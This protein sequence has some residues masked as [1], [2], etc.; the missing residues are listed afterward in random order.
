MR[1]TGGS[2]N[3]RPAFFMGT[4]LCLLLLQV[5]DCRLVVS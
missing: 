2:F 5:L 4:T 1:L 3:E